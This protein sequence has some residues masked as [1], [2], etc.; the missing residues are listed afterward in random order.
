[1]DVKLRDYESQDVGE[2]ADLF[3]DTVHRVNAEDYTPEELDAWAS[4][5]VDL[6]CWDASFR[7]HDTLVAVEDGRIVGFGDMD[8]TGYLDRLFVRWD[9]QGQGIAKAIVALLE[10]RSGLRAFRVHASLTA[11]PFFE[12][13][14]YRVVRQ[15]QAVRGGVPLAYYEMEKGPRNL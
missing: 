8:E 6:A 4:G 5:Q 2:L 11:R 13:R 9:R 1:M 10:Q 3:Y 7:A 12:G 15:Q 14:G